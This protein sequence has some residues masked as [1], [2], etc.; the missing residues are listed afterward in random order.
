M[1]RCAPRMAHTHLLLLHQ[2]R[3]EAA[4]VCRPVG[5]WV[6]H[7]VPTE[8]VHSWLGGEQRR[9]GLGPAGAPN[10]RA[11]SCRLPR[12]DRSSRPRTGPSA[13]AAPGPPA[14]PSA[15]RCVPSSGPA[16]CAW[17]HP[18]RALALAPPRRPA[19][20]RPQAPPHAHPPV[21]RIVHLVQKLVQLVAGAQGLINAPA[22][23]VV[24]HMGKVIVPLQGHIAHRVPDVLGQEA[25]VSAADTHRAHPSL[26]APQRKTQARK[27]KGRAKGLASRLQEQHPGTLT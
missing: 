26:K 2:G 19:P 8:E 6:D 18:V 16:P 14:R 11:S 3:D 23:Q 24:A 15:V 7:E 20:P 22:V 12:R 10:P 21:V 27:G 4:L 13:A 1:A 17:G 9:V 25:H 5:H